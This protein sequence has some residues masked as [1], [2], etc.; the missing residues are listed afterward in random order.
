MAEAGGMGGNGGDGCLQG[1]G[2]KGGSGKP[3]GSKGAPGKITCIIEVIKVKEVY[4]FTQGL[5]L[6]N[7]DACGE[8]HWHGTAT[9]TSGQII[10]DPA[11]D[12]CGHC[13]QSQC[14]VMQVEVK[15]PYVSES[16]SNPFD[17]S[18]AE[19]EL[20]RV[21]EGFFEGSKGASAP[22]TGRVEIRG[23]IFGN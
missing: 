4:L 11:P 14:P 3:E 8:K 15:P 12:R 17:P 9:S 20:R 5:H 6:A 16:L 10:P 7:P 2:G 18:P 1:G 13:A 21:L 19:A 22:T 23:G